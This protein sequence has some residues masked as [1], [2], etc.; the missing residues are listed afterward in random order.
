M[1]NISILIIFTLFASLINLSNQDI[2]DS[3]TLMELYN[4][5][6]IRKGI[7]DVTPKMTDNVVVEMRVY[8]KDDKSKL[9]MHA[10]ENLSQGSKTHPRCIEFALICMNVM[11]R[12]VFDCPADKAFTTGYVN[13]S[14]F[15]EVTANTAYIIDIQVFI[16]QR[17][18]IE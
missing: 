12:I 14:R 6:Q 3:P 7:N 9:I 2:T 18:Y 8:D 13:N 11:E 1:K 5:R 16:I 15:T 4:I 17:N 10:R